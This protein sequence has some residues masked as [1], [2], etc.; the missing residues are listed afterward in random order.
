MF[1]KPHTN[2]IPLAEDVGNAITPYIDKPFAL[3]GHSMG[4]IISFEVARYLRRS[5]APAPV[6]LFVSGR[7]A[8][9]L[10]DDEP[11]MYP[12]PE[13]EL[14]D[15]MRQ[16]NG[17]PKSAFEDPELM[18]LIL[19]IIR[20]DFEA[21]ETYA[22]L[23]EPPLSCPVTA[24]GGLEDQDENRER[25]EGWREHT[26]ASFSLQMFVGDHFFLHDSESDLI[27][28]ITRKLVHI[29]SPGEP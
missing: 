8:P 6:H 24:F 26:T 25:L 16:L 12:L 15:Q 19:P 2:I 11:P 28:S 29:T 5:G 18:R 14:I 20:A 22:Y 4:A 9:H 1:E 13:S 17:T 27:Q 21:V 3:F 23:P 7:R 10:T